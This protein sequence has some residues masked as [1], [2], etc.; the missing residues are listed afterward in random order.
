MELFQQNKKGNNREKNI[1]CMKCLSWNIG[2]KLKNGIVQSRAEDIVE[3]ILNSNCFVICLQEVTPFFIEYIRATKVLSST[4]QFIVI[5]PS[6]STSWGIDSF[7]MILSKMEFA[8]PFGVL[9]GLKVPLPLSSDIKSG[10]SLYENNSIDCVSCF[11]RFEGSNDDCGLLWVIIQNEYGH[12]MV[13]G[14][15]LLEPPRLKDVTEDTCRMN[16]LE[17]CLSY[18][19]SI[20]ERDNIDAL[21][22]GDL[23]IT[24]SQENDLCKLLE[25]LQWR[26]IW[27]GGKD[28]NT[29][30]T[31]K[32]ATK[33]SNKTI[34]SRPDRILIRQSSH[35]HVSD[36]S[37]FAT[38]AALR[39][40][41]HL[42]VV[43]DEPVYCPSNH[44]GL[45][46]SLGTVSRDSNA[47]IAPCR[48]PLPFL[49]EDLHM[50]PGTNKGDP[51]VIYSAQTPDPNWV[52]QGNV[53]AGS[54]PPLTGRK[55]R[56]VPECIEPQR[57]ARL[58]TLDSSLLPP[59][60]TAM[61][62][63][64]SSSQSSMTNGLSS[65]PE[66]PANRKNGCN[67]WSMSSEV[68]NKDMTTKWRDNEVIDD[69]D[70][71]I[72]EDENINEDDNK[73]V[74]IVESGGLI[75]GN[76]PSMSPPPLP[77]SIVAKTATQATQPIM[78]QAT[79]ATVMHT[80]TAAQ[81]VVNT[82][83][84]TS[85]LSFSSPPPSNSRLADAIEEGDIQAP[86][87]SFAQVLTFDAGKK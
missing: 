37:L 28:G 57:K 77:R 81:A 45:E 86:G 25:K 21:L 85:N 68:D 13:I 44:F 50:T 47:V 83:I 9:E 33:T 64:S 48:S 60:S 69:E 49:E 27:M 30:D 2:G 18:L 67:V 5:N 14:T 29:I 34:K 17:G 12:R 76:L 10:S 41:H 58:D 66:R 80:S 20:A 73:N 61:T 1:P 87:S 55:R 79:T 4:F 31:D 65:F 11:S 72:N 23:N 56:T 42:G 59:G 62:A 3:C 46:V 52:E 16:Q 74:N 6:H 43:G 71:D 24:S 8:S 38:T 40:S 36:I 7:C 26:D 35:M 70:D 75:S 51:P 22:L 84:A 15:T 54:P 63:P 53:D 32:N 82:A 78:V 39:Y 19:W